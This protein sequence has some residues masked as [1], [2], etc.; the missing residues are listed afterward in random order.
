M[1][2][3]MFNYFIIKESLVPKSKKNSFS[4]EVKRSY[5][6]SKYLSDL[7]ILENLW[8][9]FTDFIIRCRIEKR[10]Q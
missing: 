1:N 7:L 10:K 5:L 8:F 9:L 6:P 2:L 4:F 3:L